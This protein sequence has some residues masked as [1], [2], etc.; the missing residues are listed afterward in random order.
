M[1]RE[2][3]EHLLSL[4]AEMGISKVREEV[5]QLEAKRRTVPVRLRRGSFRLWVVLSIAWVCFVLA[6]LIGA[7]DGAQ[8]WEFSTVLLVLLGPPVAI[9]VA[10]IILT[11]AAIWVAG[12]FLGR[13]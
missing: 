5:D 1:S 7:V 13:A 11:K 6:L 10:S 8:R 4:A 3:F 9:F 2:R 12:G